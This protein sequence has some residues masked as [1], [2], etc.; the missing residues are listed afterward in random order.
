MKFFVLMALM[1]TSAFA[2]RVVL[3]NPTFQGKPILARRVSGLTPY[4]HYNASAVCRLHGYA[5]AA[6]NTESRD[7]DAVLLKTQ[8]VARP[9]TQIFDPASIM[10]P[11]DSSAWFDR[12]NSKFAYEGQ[13]VSLGLLT[14]PRLRFET[15]RRI[16][17]CT[18][19]SVCRNHH[20]DDF[21]DINFFVRLRDPGHPFVRQCEDWAD[22]SRHAMVFQ[23][24]TCETNASVS[25]EADMQR[26][27]NEYHRITGNRFK[28][29]ADS[30]DKIAG[31]L[32]D[33]AQTCRRHAAASSGSLFPQQGECDYQPWLGISPSMTQPR[34]GASFETYLHL[35]GRLS[36]A[37]RIS[38]CS[39]RIM[40]KYNQAAVREEYGLQHYYKTGAQL[41]CVNHV[42]PITVRNAAIGS[43]CEFSVQTKDLLQVG[44]TLSISLGSNERSTDASACEE[45]AACFASEELACGNANFCPTPGMVEVPRPR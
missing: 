5:R 42:S 39:L 6:T 9:N 40:Q 27:V 2:E 21:D 17:E 38:D 22:R 26:K 34:F 44:A 1:T 35:T 13:I 31:T 19:I 8:L 41:F 3:T 24:V 15:V 20:P 16:D 45:L 14:S 33:P 29:I 37:S 30:S 10:D 32:V 18:E 12:Y 25:W 28:V 36:R 43:S 11:V 23:E 7:P 4:E